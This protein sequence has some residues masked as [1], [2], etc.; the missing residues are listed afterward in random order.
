M[1]MASIGARLKELRKS[2]GLSQKDFCAGIC[3]SQSYYAQ[4][5]GEKREANGRILELV[6]AKYN[7]S[8]NWLKAGAGEMFGG[9]PP[10]ADLSQLVEVYQELGPLFRRHIVLQIKQLLDIQKKARGE[11]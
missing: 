7:A 1:A 2:L 3:L 5:E 6:S 4:I 9:E 10:D 11:R 8:K